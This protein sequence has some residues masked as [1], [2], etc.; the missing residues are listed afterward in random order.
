MITICVRHSTKVNLRC[1]EWSKRQGTTVTPR[2]HRD[3]ATRRRLTGLAF[4]A[5]RRPSSWPFVFAGRVG[6]LALTPSPPLPL[7][8]CCGRR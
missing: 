6:R 3:I 8:L 7:G 2:H 1:Q 4:G 5:R